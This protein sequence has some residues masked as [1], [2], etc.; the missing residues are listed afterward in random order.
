MMKKEDIKKIIREKLSEIKVNNP[1]RIN[2]VSFDT[3]KKALIQDI[4]ERYHELLD[5]EESEEDIQKYINTF[6]E[7][8]NRVSWSKG[9]SMKAFDTLSKIYEEVGFSYEQFG[10]CMLQIFVK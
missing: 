2:P 7:A 10:I 5:G 8:V 1:V 4:D 6:A 3:L 9:E